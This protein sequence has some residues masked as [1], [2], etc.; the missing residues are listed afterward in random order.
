MEGYN[1]ISNSLNNIKS[2]FHQIQGRRDYQ[3]DRHAIKVSKRNKFVHV[4]VFDGHGGDMVSEYLSNNFL[5]SLSKQ[6]LVTA[7]TIQETVDKME[8]QLI[9][10]HPRSIRTTGSTFIYTGLNLTNGRIHIG[11]IGDSRIVGCLRSNKKAMDLT[12][13]HKP[14]EKNEKARIK[15]M[16]YVPELD[17]DDEIYRV[18]GYA[19]SRAIGDLGAP[20]LQAILD[21]SEYPASSF[22]YIV[23]ATD[24][25]WDVMTSKQVVTWINRK[26]YDDQ[27]ISSQDISSQD[28]SSIVKEL[29]QLAYDKGSW[30]NISVM[31]IP[32]SK[33]MH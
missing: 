23:M 3:E 18:K 7:T 2:F 28:I 16:G 24:G 27:D 29:T 33:I 17:V 14:D 15:A 10:I 32:I 9:G 12:K 1:R 22:D 26:Y 6:S 8:R 20:P 31:I 19:L 30:D 11:N 5:K 21:Y 4:C 13:D 25:L